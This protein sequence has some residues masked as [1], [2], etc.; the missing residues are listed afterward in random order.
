MGDQEI[1]AKATPLK[2]KAS[3][4]KPGEPGVRPNVVI[5]PQKPAA[6]VTPPPAPTGNK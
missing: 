1:Q 2:A 4:V 3:Q 6:P 5:G